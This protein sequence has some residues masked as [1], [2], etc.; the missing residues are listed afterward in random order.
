ME[1]Y[2]IAR[3]FRDIRLMT[4][5]AGTTEIMYEI[6]SKIEMDEVKHEKQLIKARA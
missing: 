1:D 6:I 5:G 4:M 3:S 2:G